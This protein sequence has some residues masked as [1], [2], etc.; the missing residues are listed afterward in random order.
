[1]QK[2][3]F[4][5][6]TLVGYAEIPKNFSNDDFVFSLLFAFENELT[7]T[8][9]IAYNIGGIDNFELAKF[10][11][12]FDFELNDKWGAFAE[13]FSYFDSDYSS[14]N[15]DFG[16]LYL[17]NNKLQLDIAYGT[18]IAPKVEN[19]FITMGASILF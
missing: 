9:S 6:V 10:S 17:V 5:S 18:K 1:M 15:I 8:V 13:F 14:N 3:V 4:P 19:S 7:E 12:C 11:L 16:F 2:G